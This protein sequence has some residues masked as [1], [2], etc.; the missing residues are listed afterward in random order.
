M[1]DEQLD[2]IIEA[3]R[4]APT[5]NNL[6]NNKVIILRSLEWRE[7]YKECLQGFNQQYAV[8]GE[9]VVIFV[10]VPWDMVAKDHGKWIYDVDVHAYDLSEAE[11]QKVVEGVVN[12]YETSRASYAEVLDIYSSA[13][14]FSYMSLEATELGFGTTPMLGIL[15]SDF[16]KMLLADQLIQPGERVNMA[17]A[18]GYEDKDNER[19][20]TH[21]RIRVPKEKQFTIL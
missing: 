17:L 7:K 18:I 10:G 19:N 1:T 4:L 6:Q 20:K 9:A 21:T 5:P 13:I 16:E 11:K 2:K 8:A 14:M 15:K 12:Y 3:G